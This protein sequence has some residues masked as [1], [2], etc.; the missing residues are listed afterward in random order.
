MIVSDERTFLFVPWEK[1]CMA[2]ADG[3]QEVNAAPDGRKQLI[4]IAQATTAS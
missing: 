3:Q 2:W 1:H 4:P